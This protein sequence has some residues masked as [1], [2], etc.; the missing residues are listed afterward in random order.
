MKQNPII[1]LVGSMHSR[2]VASRRSRVLAQRVGELLKDGERVLD[3]GSGDGEIDSL[4]MAERPSITIEGLDVM[5]RTQTQIP[6]KR[7]DGLHLPFD[8]KSWDVV[9]F[10]DVLHHTTHQ[11]QLLRE[12]S[13]VARRG[14][15]IKDHLAES[16]WAHAV[17]RFM[18]WVGNRPHGVNLEY[19]YWSRAR[20]A[21]VWNSLHLTATGLHT[22]LGLYPRPFHLIFERGY[23]FTALLQ[24]VNAQ[25]AGP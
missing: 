3:V 6:V 19:E 25:S 23:H 4:I 20:W 15:L 22:D 5:V 7:F 18:D 21:A 8:D 12:A 1:S 17:L 14:V 13:R 9:M 11:V 2:C 16:W 24:S 10:V